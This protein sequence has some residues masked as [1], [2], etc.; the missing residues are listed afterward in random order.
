MIICSRLIPE[1]RLANTDEYF[2]G[3]LL[4]SLS[5][6]FTH[7][8]SHLLFS[9]APSTT[10][11]YKRCLI[12]KKSLFKNLEFRASQTFHLIKINFKAKLISIHFNLTPVIEKFTSRHIISQF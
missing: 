8:L 3:K 12:K 1:V 11:S 6:F 9:V 2:E 10:V 4:E 5:N 7:S